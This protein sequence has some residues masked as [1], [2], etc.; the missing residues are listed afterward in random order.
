MR[1]RSVDPP[2]YSQPCRGVEHRGHD[3]SQAKV[4]AV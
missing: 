4:R 3:L 2:L 1:S